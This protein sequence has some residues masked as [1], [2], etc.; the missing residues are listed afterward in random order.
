MRAVVRVEGECDGSAGE[1][2]ECER[3]LGGVESVGAADDQFHA[4][5]ERLGSGVA[6]FQASGC[7]DPVAVLADRFALADETAVVGSVRG[8]PGAGRAASSDSEGAGVGDVHWS[9]RLGRSRG[10]DCPDRLGTGLD[11]WSTDRDVGEA[12]A[13]HGRMWSRQRYR[14]DLQCADHGDLLRVRDPAAGVLARRPRRSKSR[15]CCGQMS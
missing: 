14:G 11:A 2:D 3:G 5:V 15:R 4:A 13:D 12:V 8:G 9:W 6:D 7:K 10:S 1:V